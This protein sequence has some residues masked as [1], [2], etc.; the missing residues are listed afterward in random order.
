MKKISILLFLFLM[1]SVLYARGIQEDYRN[2]EEKAR[3]SYA[4][5]MIIGHNFNLGSLDMDFDFHALAEGIRALV[6]ESVEAQFSEQEAMEIVETA[7]YL[8]MERVSERNQRMEINFLAE[9]SQREGVRVTPSGLQYEII[10]YA[11]G[12]K[13]ESNSV[14]RV[15]Y[16]GIFIDGSPFDSSFEEEGSYIPLELVITG[17]T[18]GLMLMSPGSIYRF[19]IPSNL[20]YGKEGIPGAIPPYST[21]I[22]NVELIEILNDDEGFFF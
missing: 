22:F 10:E 21:L 4:F 5:G 9:N 6:D 1:A 12:D 3:I 18:E 15:N 14:V 2:A 20:A 19:Y 8:A 13:P 17:W 11:D 7:I 16:T